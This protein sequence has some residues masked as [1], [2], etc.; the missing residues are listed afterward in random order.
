[1]STVRSRELTPETS[2]AREAADRVRHAVRTLRWAPAP[3]WEEEAPQRVRFLAYLSGS[4]L[5]WTAIGLSGALLLGRATESLAT[6][7]L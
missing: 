6:L 3:Q 7:A 4:M 1:M 2:P 5:G